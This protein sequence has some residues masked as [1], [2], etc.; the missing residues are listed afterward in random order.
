M[1]RKILQTL[2]LSLVLNSAVYG[3]DYS[4][5]TGAAN[6]SVNAWEGFDYEELGLTQWEFQQA[7]E[8]GLDRDKLLKL[9]ELGI[10]P[11]EY[12][13]KPWERLGVT[14]A[15][16]LQ[17]RTAGMDDSD[18]DRSYRNRAGLQN[19]AYW[20]A[21]VPSLYQ[22]KSGKTTEAITMNAIWGVCLGTYIYL[23]ITTPSNDENYTLLPMLAVHVWSFGDGLMETQW[24]NN[25][26]AN[27]FSF[28]IAPLRN[29]VAGLFLAS[30]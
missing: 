10:R 15:I 19:F 8:A 28:G 27:R 16:W 18:I 2:I 29:G 22:W 30:F 7:R 23:A 25:P 12:L 5:S 17:E 20:S 9:L 4:E 6:A 13:Q 1:V 26:D 24:E 14:E 3:L 11:S 21:L